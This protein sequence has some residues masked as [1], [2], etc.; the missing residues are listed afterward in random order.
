MK[1]HFKIAIGTLLLALAAPPAQA[2]EKTGPYVG[3]GIGGGSADLDDEVDE[4][5]GG[6]V[7]DD[8]LG[9]VVQGGYRV[10][11]WFGV[12]GR[13]L[14]AANDSN[15]SAD[16]TFGG[17]GAQVVGFAPVSEM[18]DLF[19]TLGYY[20]GSFEIDE[21]IDFFSDND[22]TVSGAMYGAGLLLNLG[23]GGNF[24]VRLEYSRHDVGELVDAVDMVAVS[25]QYNFYRK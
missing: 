22:E 4:I 1:Q 2:F 19:A 13:V 24:G 6:F 21:D 8:L 10:N 20:T 5:F 17:I 9:G 3:G 23:S 25:F 16:I 12:E 18:V 11:R 7:D 14:G 15:D